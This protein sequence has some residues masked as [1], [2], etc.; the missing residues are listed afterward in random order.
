MYTPAPPSRG[1]WF[2]ALPPIAPLLP[3][4]RPYVG[5]LLALY[6]LYIAP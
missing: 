1:C 3:L 2:G 6:R 4:F 5:P